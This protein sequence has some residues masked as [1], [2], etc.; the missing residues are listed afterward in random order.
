[1]RGR[2]W[3]RVLDGFFHRQSIGEELK[4]SNDDMVAGLNATLN[5]VVVADDVADLYLLLARDS[6]LRAIR[7]D[8]RKELPVYALRCENGNFKAFGSTPSDPR[9]HELVGSE[10]AIRI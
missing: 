10:L 1:M 9:A 7:G 2:L 6:P 3:W 8:E 5:D 4:T